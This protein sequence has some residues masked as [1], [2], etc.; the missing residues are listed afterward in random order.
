MIKMVKKYVFYCI[1]FLLMITSCKNIAYIKQFPT[2]K[3]GIMDVVHWDFD[4]QGPIPLSGEWEYYDSSYIH[5]I[6]L[7]APCENSF[8]KVPGNNF[9]RNTHGNKN[10]FGTYRL[11]LVV[12]DSLVGRESGFKFISNSYS[13][14][15]YVDNK[16]LSRIGH[17][18]YNAK[19][20]L[21]DVNPHVALYT[22]KNNVME[23]VIHEARFNRHLKNSKIIWFGT[24]DQLLK[25]REK[26]LLKEGFLFG[27]IFL[28]GFMHVL[29][30]LFRKKDKT[31]LYLAL[32]CIFMNIRFFFMGE[33]YIDIIISGLSFV[34]RKK[35]VFSLLFISVLFFLRFFYTM[36][37][38]EYSIKIFR[39][40]SCTYYVC[41]A[42]VLLLPLHIFIYT[43]YFHH[44]I[45]FT[46]S[47]YTIMVMIKAV[48][49][50]KR[51]ALILL[52]GFSILLFTIINDILS[53]HLIVPTRYMIH[54]GLFIFV[55]FILVYISMINIRTRNRIDYLQNEL[56]LKSL[57]LSKLQKDPA[58]LNINHINKLFN[59]F[60][61]TSREQE[62]ILLILK[63][64]TN[65]EIADELFISYFTVRRHI[66]NIYQKVGSK[67]RNDL[68]SIF[69]VGMN[70][71]EL[72]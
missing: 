19:E 32:F 49:Q 38:G 13:I 71:R 21:Y 8:K 5:P 10:K 35:M 17:N 7:N 31:P 56:K 59:E 66:S 68:I 12:P 69:N 25:L 30:F 52:S 33:S 3:K 70:V 58:V 61:I 55:I 16:I 63:G 48:K 64:K 11:I 24:G 23:I 39:C 22:P 36:F 72:K 67:S 20:T 47:I 29:L 42:L 2:A 28:V 41:I 6:H 62:L 15:F 53:Y 44:L 37:P 27:N 46:G 26:T 18:A 51:L 45:V 1:L 57:E 14:A 34:V 40:I 43:I 60:K 4:K 65:K 54:Y 9:F 50:K